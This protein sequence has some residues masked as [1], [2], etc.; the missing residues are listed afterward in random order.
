[1][2]SLFTVISFPAPQVHC[3]RSLF[4]PRPLLDSTPMGSFDVIKE[5]QV[6]AVIRARR[7]ADPVGLV[8]TL[9][10][11]GIRSIEFTFTI[12]DLITV[13]ASAASHANIGAGTALTAE[14]TESA[15]K[16]GAAFCRLAGPQA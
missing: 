1:M 13:I 5:D 7:V 8:E 3:I 16:A 11:A 10:A 4:L 6:V 14:Q 15:I 9:A 12:P 2:P